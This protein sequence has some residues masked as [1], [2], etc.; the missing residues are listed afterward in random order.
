MDRRWIATGLVGITA[1]AVACVLLWPRTERAVAV[2]AARDDPAA[3]SDIQLDSALRNDPGLLAREAEAA[4]AAG[5]ID[6]ADSFAEVAV[7]RNAILSEGLRMRI[8]EAVA[9]ENSVGR[10]AERFA[11]GLVTGQAEDA[12]G[13]TGVI[14]GDLFVFGDIRDVLREG[15]HVVMGEDGDRVILGLAAAGLAVT[16]ATYLSAGGAAPVRAGLTMVKDARKAGRMSAGLSRWAGR[17]A[18]DLVDP[19]VLQKALATGS[20]ARPDQVVPAVKTA[21]RMEKAGALVRVAKDVG[22]IGKRAGTRGAFDAMKLA[23]GP[24]DIARAARLAEAKGGQTRAILK[25]LGRGAFVLA[26]GAFDLTLWLFWALI[27]AFGFIVSI[28]TTTERFTLSL[29][30]RR[31]AARAK[32]CHVAIS[33]SPAIA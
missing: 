22:R 19:P 5:D 33:A 6:L 3:L 8:T 15:K 31:K 28:K 32:L 21:F 25:M 16:A 18:R 13:L 11:G 26:V 9:E 27:A 2:L 7:A 10:L 20:F 23:E 1:C 17:S 30:R 29:L 12:A 14:A 24:K 4:L